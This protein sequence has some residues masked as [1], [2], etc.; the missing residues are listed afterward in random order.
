MAAPEAAVNGANRAK[1]GCEFADSGPF[2]SRQPLGRAARVGQDGRVEAV[3]I[4]VGD[5]RLR[6]WR[7]QD[8]TAVRR[9]CADPSLHASAGEA[10]AFVRQV[11][12]AMLA[13]GTGVPLG[14]FDVRTGN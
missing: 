4:S 5:L 2:T 6:P 11:A 7:P 1:V 3:E 8:A 9:A 12:P 13:D 14:V 10:E